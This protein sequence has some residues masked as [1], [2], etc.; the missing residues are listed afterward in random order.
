MILDQGVLGEGG[1]KIVHLNVA[2]I[3]GAHKFEMLKQQISWSGYDVFCASETW[4]TP[5]LPDKLIEVPGFVLAR[6]DR[7]WIEGAEKKNMLC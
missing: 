3:L 5:N 7:S 2:S 4:L 1:L 6:V